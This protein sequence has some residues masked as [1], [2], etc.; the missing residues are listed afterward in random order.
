MGVS[1]A[2]LRRASI[3]TFTG[4]LVNFAVLTLQLLW[5]TPLLIRTVGVEVNGAWVGSGDLL[6]W[7]QAFDFGLTNYAIQKMSDAQAR[8]R[9]PELSGWFAATLGLLAA[10]G[11]LIVLLG[12][13]LAPLVYR[14]FDLGAAERLALEGA[15]RWGLVAVALTIVSYAFTGLAR[16]LQAPLVTTVAVVLGSMLGVAVTWWAL[17][18]GAGVAAVA[19]GMVARAGV[20]LAGGVLAL[21]HFR[22]RRA[23]ELRWPQGAYVRES[24]GVMPY[25]GVGALGY[26]L[27][28]QSDNLLVGYLFGPAT[29]TMFNTTR[30]A[31]DVARSVIETLG[32]ANFAGFSHVYA[33]DGAAGGRASYGRILNLHTLLSLALCGGFIV[34]NEEFVR[35]WIGERF[36]MSDLVN[37]LMGLQVFFAT[38][39]YLLNTLNRGMSPPRFA[40]VMLAVEASAK[41]LLIVLVARSFGVPMLLLIGMGVAAGVGLVMARRN[42]RVLGPVDGQWLAVTLALGLLGAAQAIHPWL[43]MLGLGLVVLGGLGWQRSVA[44]RGAVQA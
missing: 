11:L 22:T 15:F 37:T 12:P 29:A 34:F 18:H 38:R 31:A 1:D 26:A 8:A 17:A 9:V 33:R 21:L 24:L 42:A 39:S 14:P 28:N 16:A 40:F 20:S 30:R 7:L 5:I 44:S 25:S 19:Y 43:G 27:G 10:L 23:V 3:I 41:V 35:L 36:Y 2:Q 13:L 4:T 6:L 32:Y